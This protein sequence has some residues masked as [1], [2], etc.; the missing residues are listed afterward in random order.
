LLG[1]DERQWPDGAKDFLDRIYNEFRN[2]GVSPQD[3]ALN[4][5]AM[6]ALNTNQIFKAEAK[7]RRLD[8]VDVD[9]STICRPDSLCYDV[10]YRFF[11]PINVL[12]QA[13]Q[14]YQYTIDVSDVVPVPVGRVRSWA[15]Y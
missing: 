11:D 6:N 13:R 12:T 9:K 7:K 8:T 14:V 15:V 2:A 10:T 4:Y 5:S 3:R 1:P